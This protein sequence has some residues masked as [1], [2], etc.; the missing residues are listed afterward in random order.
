[1]TRWLPLLT[2]GCAYV[3]FDAGL[4]GAAAS[5]NVL[6][7]CPA[8]LHVTDQAT[9]AAECHHQAVPD[10]NHIEGC[11]KVSACEIY[12]SDDLSPERY[13]VVLLHELG[14]LLKGDGGHL[15]CGGDQPGD[16]IMCPAG[17]SD[18]TEPTARDREFVLR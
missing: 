10:G 18:G 1:M 4:A 13:Q 14:H 11:A 3:P 5:W 17:A 12:I 16:D 15:D 2:L 6:E 9:V 7:M 8:Q